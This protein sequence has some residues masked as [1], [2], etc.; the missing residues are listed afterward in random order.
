MVKVLSLPYLVPALLRGDNAAMKRSVRSQAADVRAH[1][2]VCV[3]GLGLRRRCGTVASRG[4]VLEVN[5]GGQSMR[6]H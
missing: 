4:A 1:V 3:A 5:V 2:L 6:I